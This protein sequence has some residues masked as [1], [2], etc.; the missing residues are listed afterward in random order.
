M[1]FEFLMI[2]LMIGFVSAGTQICIDFDDPSAPLDLGISGNVGSILLEW[3]AAV[4]EPDCSGIAEY[5]ISREG[6]EIGK[7]NGDVL[8]FVDNENLSEGEYV[9]TVYAVDLIGHN[10]GVAIKNVVK[11][12]GNNNDGGTSGGNSGGSYVCVEDWGCDAWSECIGNE[13]RRLCSDLNKCGTNNSKP[14]TYQEC[15]LMSEANITLEDNEPEDN[16]ASIIVKA[17]SAITGAVVG[18]A[19]TPEGVAVSTFIL[20]SLLGFT[21]VRIRRKRYLNN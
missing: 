9:Y 11:V 1:R 3:G 14:E 21:A 7:V 20:L 2:I 13:Q 17:F 10:T 5:V 18:A 4:D 19:G 12:G 16:G 8:S 6:L 15:G